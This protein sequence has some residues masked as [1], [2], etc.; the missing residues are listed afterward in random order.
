MTTVKL[1]IPN[2]KS[3]HCQMTVSETVTS[4]GATVAAVRSGEI[5]ITINESLSRET[6]VAAVEGKGYRV[7][8]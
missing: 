2:M 1:T 7:S 5:E 4:L 6:V 8:S 3:S